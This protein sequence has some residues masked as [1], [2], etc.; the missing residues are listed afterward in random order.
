LQVIRR[1]GISD[2]ESYMDLTVLRNDR[3]LQVREAAA[4]ILDMR[5]RNGGVWQFPP[6]N[7]IGDR[8]HDQ[9]RTGSGW[10]CPRSE[11][12]MTL[13]CERETTNQAL[14]FPTEEKTTPPAPPIP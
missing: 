9:E 7:R 14:P 13:L 1:V 4:E 5:A 12:P 11:R 8:W 6:M 2:L 10:P 3:N